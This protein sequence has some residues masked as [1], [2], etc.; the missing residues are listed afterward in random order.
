VTTSTTGTGL[1]QSLGIGSGLDVNSLVTKLVAAERAPVD[2]RL[3]RQA[4]D[5]ATQVS[6]LGTLKGA[7]S[8]FQTAIGPLASGEQFAARSATSGNTDVFTASASSTAVAGNYTVEV[9]QLAQ[10]EQLISTA[11]AGGAAVVVG[12]G[13]LTLQLGTS[14]SFSVTLDSSHN[15]LADIRD[16]INSATDN[17]GI[18]AALVYG[19]NGAQLVLASQDTG[20]AN[21]MAVSASGG[22]GGL[23]KL[24]YAVGAT[25]N[26]TEQQTAQDAIVLIS[27]VEHHSASNV[28]DSAL[29]GV[30]LTLKTSN[31]GSPTTLTVNSDQTTILANVNKFVNAYNSMEG[32]LATLGSYNAAT[33]QGGPLLGDWLLSSISDAMVRGTTDRV[34][35]ISSSYSSLAAIGVTTGSDGR[36]SVDNAKLTAAL[37][38][39]P[40]AI[41]AL[42][43]GGSGIATR[44]NSK[45]DDLLASGGA[46][47]ARNT[48]LNTAQTQI[49]D[50]TQ[51]LNDQMGVVQQRYLAQFTALDS[52]MAQLQST[53][54]YLTQQL[55]NAASIGNG[56]S[57]KSG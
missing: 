57:T 45:V 14:H 55:A 4:S 47:A 1:I 54:N 27:G 10:P 12:T 26:Y 7:L 13:T 16:A 43:G 38:A 28:V 35:G 36:L 20:A 37:Q 6:A 49:N 5:V 48:D 17:P 32:Q 39:N 53:S 3:T 9:Q 40:T 42:F 11:F 22:D 24:T 29:D 2:N 21:T 44:L 52:L 34:A 25:S 31:K 46:I 23:S 30:T 8:A 33:K 15:T 51:K 18:S 56:S 41:A 50:D 19:I